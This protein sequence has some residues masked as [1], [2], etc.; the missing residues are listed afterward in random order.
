[1]NKTTLRYIL[2]LCQFEGDSSMIRKT[3]LILFTLWLSAPAAVAANCSSY[4]LPY[5]LTNGQTADAT[6]VMADLNQIINCINNLNSS[7]PQVTVLTSG[8]NATYTTPANA[9]YLTVEMVGGGGGG[10][11]SG[12][13]PGAAT[14]GGN[15]CWNTSGTA[16]TSPLF[17]ANG[18]P[19][20]QSSSGT[21]TPGGTA[22]GCDLNLTGGEGGGGPSTTTSVGG[23]GGTSVFGGHGPGGNQGAGVAA[24]PGTGSGGGGAGVTT[25]T[26]GGSGGGAGGY[27]RKMITGPVA[28]YVYTVGGG[29]LGGAGGTGG[30]PGAGGGSAIII[31]TAY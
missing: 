16:C 2:I 3:L 20:G 22:L 12:T 24:Q 23:P 29:G 17:A 25:T 5:P 18:G 31:V 15:T 27:C 4:P 13:S 19:A 1:M 6:Q 30:N 7:P 9:K 8:T 21:P 14:A 10:G 11:G 28:S 26:N